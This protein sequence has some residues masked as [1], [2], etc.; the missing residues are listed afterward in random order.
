MRGG[1]KGVGRIGAIRNTGW[2]WQKVHSGG[3]RGEG[4]QGEVG[5]NSKINRQMEGKWRKREVG[6]K[7]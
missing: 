4:Q 3:R 1:L 2:I 5:I 7:G 6:L